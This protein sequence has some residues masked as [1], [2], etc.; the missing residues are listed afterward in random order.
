MNHYKKYKYFKWCLIISVLGLTAFIINTTGYK[1]FDIWFLSEKGNVFVSLILFLVIMFILLVILFSQLDKYLQE[2]KLSIDKFEEVKFENESLKQQI[3]SLQKLYEEK[4][5]E[6]RIML[7]MITLILQNIELK[8]VLN[9]SL[10]IL[11]NFLKYD[12]AIVY[13]YDRDKNILECVSGYN[14]EYTSLKDFSIEI[15]KHPDNFIV[16]TALQRKPYIAGGVQDFT[17]VFGIFDKISHPDVIAAVP[18]EAKEKI[19]GVLVVD[20]I[21]TKRR[22]SQKDVRKLIE[23]TDM[24]GLAIENARLYETEKNFS[25]QLNIKLNEAIN[26]LKEAQ[27]QTIRAETLAALGRMSTVISHEIR[28]MLVAIKNSAEY[29]LESKKTNEKTKYIEFILKEVE[30]LNKIVDDILAVGQKIHIIPF[31][32]DINKFIKDIIE[33]VKLME[34]EKEGIELVVEVENNLPTGFFDY[35]RI[36][37]VIINIVQNAI[38]FLKTAIKKEI[39]IKVYL[40]R[41]YLVFSISDSGCGIPDDI[42]DKIFDPF[43]STK[44][45]GTGLGLTISKNIVLAHE[46]EIFVESEYGKGATFYIKIPLKKI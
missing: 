40:E 38:Y 7:K 36:K 39:K 23:F 34:I 35:N 18:L 9:V 42:K 22:I 30:R 27:Q 37:Q 20:N 28:N 31:P 8:K 14:V 11:C 45:N 43:F 29:L 21:K 32:V 4:N 6:Y 16:K 41:E 17:S 26:K 46:G 15:D 24:I 33:T 44:P 3:S 12:R 10:E 13:L 19:V 25:E 2:L 5:I 1:I